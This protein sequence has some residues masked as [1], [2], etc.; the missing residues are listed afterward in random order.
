MNN[1]RKTLSFSVER[2]TLIEVYRKQVDVVN[3][4]HMAFHY[5]IAAMR[6]TSSGEDYKYCIIMSYL[7]KS[8]LYIGYM[9]L[10]KE[11]VNK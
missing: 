5:N 7:Y 8:V 9:S 1:K 11:M 10:Y 4:R 2:I 6:K 3:R